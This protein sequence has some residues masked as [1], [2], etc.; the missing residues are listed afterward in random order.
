MSLLSRILRPRV[1]PPE[2]GDAFESLNRLRDLTNEM[3]QMDMEIHNRADWLR[4]IFDSIDIPVWAKGVDNRFMYANKAC[5][6]TILR[7]SL[8]EAMEATDTDF[9]N[10]ALAN[11]CIR[12]D[13][14]TKTKREAC[15]FIE[16]SVY[17][18]YELWLDT[19]K[20]PWFKDDEVIG[21]VGTAKIITDII[22][23]EIRNRF[24]EPLL[25][26]IPADV[27]L[28]PKQVAKLVLAQAL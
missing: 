2:F 16:H 26:E 25:I 3:E 18:D 14:I 17:V 9:E 23:K 12:S 8:D 4:Q 22:P 1:S 27:C 28:T 15:R 19:V 10:N 7:C 11:V 5:C 21:T 6:D 24:R 13:E 20:S